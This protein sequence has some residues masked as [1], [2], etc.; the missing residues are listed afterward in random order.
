MGYLSSTVLER[1]GPRWQCRNV[2][3]RDFGKD[4][5]CRSDW[6]TVGTQKSMKMPVLPDRPASYGMRVIKVLGVAFR[7]V[8]LSI[9]VVLP[10]GGPGFA[11]HL[12]DEVTIARGE[13]T[14]AIADNRR[15]RNH[16]LDFKLTRSVFDRS[17]AS[18]TTSVNER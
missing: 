3:D 5:G 8:D 9:G 1:W 2:G 14:P 10:L 11:Q 7:V 16:L 18:S 6:H 4:K 13:F 17:R 12:T 15:S